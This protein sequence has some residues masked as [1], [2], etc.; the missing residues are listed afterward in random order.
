MFALALSNIQNDVAFSL[1][2]AALVAFLLIVTIKNKINR[3]GLIATAMVFLAFAAAIYNSN[4]EW[5]VP[6][7]TA[8]LVIV[9]YW[10]AS[11]NQELVKFYEINLK[12]P[13]YKGMVKTILSSIRSTLA[14][15]Y[16]E[17]KGGGI[18]WGF[19]LNKKRERGNLSNHFC[20][21]DVNYSDL[22]YFPE[23]V[24]NGQLK[25]LKKSV[26]D[27]NEVKSRFD[28]LVKT[29]YEKWNVMGD[30]FDIFC[31]NLNGYPPSLETDFIFAAII[32]EA[33]FPQDNEYNRFLNAEKDRLTAKLKE[34][35]FEDDMK[36]YHHYKVQ[37]ISSEKEINGILDNI[38]RDWQRRFGLEPE[39]FSPLK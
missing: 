37:I 4:P 35:S 11:S 14:M 28:E 1:A 29:I 26:S 25:S 27:Y 16:N 17:V 20:P 7:L 23:E 34:M 9:T 24:F 38:Y 6:F 5:A 33:E 32:A 19:I 13:V 30:E 22:P 31:R 12:R 3:L 15:N 39:E 2:V 10:Y 18:I 21:I 36:N 8:D